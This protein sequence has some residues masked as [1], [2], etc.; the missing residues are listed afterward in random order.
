MVDANSAYTL[1][2]IEI[3]QRLDDFNLLM[4]EQPLATDDIVDHAKIAE[5][6]KRLFA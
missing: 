3:L 5:K 1:E 6:L 4:I 2:D